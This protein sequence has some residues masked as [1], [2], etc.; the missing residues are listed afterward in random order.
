MLFCDAFAFVRERKFDVLVLVYS[1]NDP[2]VLN[3]QFRSVSSNFVQLRATHRPYG[4]E[5]LVAR[6]DRVDLAGPRNMHW[7]VG[8]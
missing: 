4:R 3:Q 8:S 1:S 6:H 2:T 5:Y 7:W